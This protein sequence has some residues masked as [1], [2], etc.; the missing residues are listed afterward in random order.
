MEKIICFDLEGPLSPQD[1]A[2]ELM[3][4]I[5]NGD[6]IFEIISKYD[7]ILALESREGYEPGDTLKLIAPFLMLHGITEQDIKEVSDRA[8]LVKGT[9]ELIEG[10]QEN[11]WK[12]HIIST[13]YEQHAY[14]TA[15]RCGVSTS[16]VACTFF[17][18]NRFYSSALKTE[19]YVIVETAENSINRIID[20]YPIDDLAGDRKIKTVLD[21]FYW[22]TLRKNSSWKEIY[23]KISV[24]GGRRKVRA[25]ESILRYHSYTPQPQIYFSDAV[26]V[27]DSITDYRMLE[28]VESAGGLAI[29]FNGNEYALSHGTVGLATTDMRNIQLILNAWKEEGRN[30]LKQVILRKEEEQTDGSKSYYHWIIGKKQEEF[31]EILEIH[32][33]FRKLVRGEAAKLG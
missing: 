13:S 15:Y 11:E 9:K 16:K 20:L 14:N 4:L 28:V 17:P 10:L 2:F 22:K 19:D 25:L 27:G 3:K 29:V 21:Q 5:P 18:L 6:K 7:D 33:K 1:N 12:V 8:E 31:T 26:V 24:V 23:K 30:V 32:K